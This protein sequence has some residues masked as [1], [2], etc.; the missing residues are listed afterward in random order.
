MMRKIN[1][2]LNLKRKKKN[3]GRDITSNVPTI[4]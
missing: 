1:P 2:N 4:Y 3:K